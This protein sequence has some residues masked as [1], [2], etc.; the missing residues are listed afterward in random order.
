MALFAGMLLITA[1]LLFAPQRAAAQNERRFVRQGNDLF[2]EAVKDTTKL[3]TMRFSQAEEAYRRALEK[4]PGHKQWDFNL[5]DAIYKQMRFAEAERKFDELAKTLETPEEQARALH[6]KGN[7][8]LF[9]QQ[10][11]QSIE[12]YKE[13]LRRHPDDL[14]TK[15]N[16]AWA[17]RMKKKQEQQQQQQ[18]QNQDQNQ[19]QQQQQQQDQQNQDQQQ[20][21]Q[22][23]Q[24][25]NQDQQQQNQDQQQQQNQDQQN[26]DQQ[27]QQP[28]KISKQDADQL[29]QALENDERDIQEKV[30]KQQAEKGQRIRT[31]KEW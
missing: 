29:L 20:Q 3:D 23:Q 2:M 4:K 25:Q 21:N 17:Q 19:D 22:D 12:S 7:S 26:Q 13:A 30:Q 27:Q 31:E 11:D 16:L 8:Q 1:T 15:Y 24:Q 6:N 9:Q 10:I 14:D 28:Y 5:A 18:Q